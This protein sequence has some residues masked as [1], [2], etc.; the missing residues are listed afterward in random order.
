[1]CSDKER[2]LRQI[3]HKIYN[4][5]VGVDKRLDFS[6]DIV[7]REFDCNKPVSAASAKVRN[8]ISH[9]KKKIRNRSKN[10]LNNE[11]AFGQRQ[12]SVSSTNHTM[13]SRR[14]KPALKNVKGLLSEEM[15]FYEA[16]DQ[17]IQTSFV[18]ENKKEQELLSSNTKDSTRKE[19]K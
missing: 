4:D 1:L 14:K 9:N 11:G 6:E 17:E 3:Q 13:E 15:E 2:E 16:E 8:F 10:K 5:I 12:G 18:I 19:N 7:M